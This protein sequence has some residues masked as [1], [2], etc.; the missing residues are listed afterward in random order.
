MATR[1]QV[2][3]CGVRSA[4]EALLAAS[5]GA[6]LLGLNFHPPSP[7][8]LSVAEAK[9]ITAAMHDLPKRPLLVGV[10]VHPSPAEASALGEELGLDLLQ[11]H[12]NHQ[13]AEVA[14]YAHKVLAALRIEGQPTAADLAPWR[15]IGVWGLVLD[16]RHPSLFGGTGES[17]DFASV[18]GLAA[19]GERLLIAGGLKPGNVA[20]AIGAARPWG[21]D[22]CSG[23]ET[24][25][26]ERSPE[27]LQ[28]LFQSLERF[29]PST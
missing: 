3:I 15:A 5:L 12:G 26:G 4:E 21:I 1:P 29:S 23:V 27:L 8:C 6:D 24:A 19:P 14:P 7:R 13:P 17:W 20:A 25:P 9:T 10:F 22:L 28:Q 18:A 11:L 16:T 2:K